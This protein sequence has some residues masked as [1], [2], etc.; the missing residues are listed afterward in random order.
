MNQLTG[1]P[2]A[3][4][5]RDL[6]AAAKTLSDDEARFL[7]DA[8]YTMQ[9]NRIRGAAQERE[10]TESG[11]P[12]S[13]LQWLTAQDAILEQQIKRALNSY[14]ESKPVG[15][16]SL[17][18]YGIGPVIS[19]G[20]LAHIDITRAPTVGHVWSFAGL[21]P[22]K[23]WE[24]KTKRPWNASLKTL[25]WKVGQSFMKFSNHEECRYGRIY[26]ERKAIEVERNEAGQFAEQAALALTRKRYGVETGARKA[27][28]A[29]RLPPAHIDARARR[30]AVKLFLAHW[31][32]V[33]FVAH[34]GEKPPLPYPISHL[35][36]AHVIN[37]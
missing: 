25:C 30:Y 8:Y 32:E 2:V 33:A 13:V 12:H 1:E 6:V 36:H 28:E 22:T 31:H 29:G 27:Y 5:S 3:R 18:I 9:E 4:L 26:R 17:S 37:P 23:T 35:G 19:A 7:V 20:L 14:A 16:W 34:Y 10:L 15:Q 11:E 21:D 24:K